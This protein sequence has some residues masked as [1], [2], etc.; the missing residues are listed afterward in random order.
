MERS[1]SI[2]EACKVALRRQKINAVREEGRME[3]IKDVAAD[4][5]RGKETDRKFWALIKKHI[6][7]AGEISRGDLGAKMPSRRADL[8]AALPEMVKVG[9]LSV[10]D[11]EYNS[12]PAEYYSI[13]KRE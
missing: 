12:R 11:G 4:D 1:V 9:I 7:A 3:G 6:R 5:S 2:R 10:R 8:K 13:K